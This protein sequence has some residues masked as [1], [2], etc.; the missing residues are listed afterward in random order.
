ME[1]ASTTEQ[2]ILLKS[3]KSWVV[4]DDVNRRRVAYGNKREMEKRLKELNTKET[5]L[6]DKAEE[7]HRHR[8]KSPFD[9][10]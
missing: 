9:L 4:W 7:R 5:N 6:E 1:Q 8:N 10:M 2:F 3:Y